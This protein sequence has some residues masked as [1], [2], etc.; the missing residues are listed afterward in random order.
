MSNM[1]RSLQPALSRVSTLLRKETLRLFYAG[2]FFYAN[3]FEEDKQFG[4]EAWLRSIGERNRKALNRFTVITILDEGEMRTWAEDVD[5][6]VV[7]TRST[8]AEVVEIANAMI[9]ETYRRMHNVWELRFA[10]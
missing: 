9:D 8:T 3:R 2:N 4:A 5:P 7:V 10:R 1:S 6:H